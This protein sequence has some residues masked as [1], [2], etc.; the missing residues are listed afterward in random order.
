MSTWHGRMLPYPLLAPWTDD[1]DEQSAFAAEVPEAVLNN[2]HKINVS[3]AFRL[4]SVSLHGLIDD[5][6]AVYAVDISCPRTFERT[7]HL[8]EQR[9][10]LVLDAGNYDEDLMLT[11][12]VVSKG[13]IKGFRSEEHALEWRV[14]RPGGFR[15]PAAGILAVGNTTR[16]AL[17]DS[18][19]NSVIDLVSNPGVPDGSF[20]VELDDDRIKIHVPQAEKARIEAVRNRRTSVEF[21]ALY[22]GL[23][24]HAVVEAVRNLADYRSSRWAFTIRSALDRSGYGGVD[25]EV[26]R[27][28]ALRFAQILMEQPVGGFLAEALRSDGEDQGP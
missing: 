20:T 6:K 27:T 28:D 13:E 19:V 1:Y 26:L 18:A 22:P 21:A 3:L 11:P 14:H 8:A 9:Q 17:E 4:L 15:V 7:T 12:Y 10:T 5:D 16:I 25:H 23:Y 24:L 2:G